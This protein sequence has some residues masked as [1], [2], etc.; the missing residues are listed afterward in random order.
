MTKQLTDYSPAELADFAAE[1]HKDF[2]L[3]GANKL[4]LNLS[5]GKPAA[6][7]LALSNNMESVIGGNYIAA[8]GTDVRNYGEIRGVGEARELGAELLGVPVANVMA[9]GNS[10]LF[11]MHLVVSTALNAGLWGDDRKWSAHK[12]PKILT[13]VPGY[14]RHFALTESLGIEMVNV[15]IGP[16]GPRTGVGKRRR[17]H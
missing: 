17:Q 16:D 8:D 1:L 7:Q 10:S 2:E 9:G 5:R 13:P 15:D 4:A 12:A 3:V 11:L 14:D 6:D